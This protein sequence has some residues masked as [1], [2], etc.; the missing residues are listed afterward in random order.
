M[1]YDLLL[2]AGWDVEVEGKPKVRR[3]QLIGRDRCFEVSSV[4]SMREEV[5]ER[6]ESLG[7]RHGFRVVRWTPRPSKPWRRVE[8]EVPRCVWM[9]GTC[10]VCTARNG[11]ELIER[12]CVEEGLDV[13][14]VQ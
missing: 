5:L 7:R 6:L 2:E 10:N 9:F 8:C 4:Q 12:V 11:V 13:C 1:V 14:C 3:L